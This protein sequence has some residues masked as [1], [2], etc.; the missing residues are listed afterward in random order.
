MV[1]CEYGPEV[2][3]APLPGVD[4]CAPVASGS[5]VDSVKDRL[6]WGKIKYMLFPPFVP[7]PVLGGF[8]E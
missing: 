8:T 7:Y 3:R 5:T 2:L 6:L 1:E 4:L